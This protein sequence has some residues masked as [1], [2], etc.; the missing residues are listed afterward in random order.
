MTTSTVL[1]ASAVLAYLGNETGAEQVQTAISLGSY[2]STINWTEVLS[3]LSDKGNQ[4]HSIA[5]ELKTSG[6]VGSA[7]ELIPFTMEDAETAAR[8][9][10]QTKT[11]GLS[12]GDRSCLALALRLKLPVLTSDRS[13]SNLDLGI[14]VRNIR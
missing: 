4:I 13:W 1:D 7:I 10:K 9:R 11:L 6:L 2:L 3:K 12:I 5:E 8:L 14:S